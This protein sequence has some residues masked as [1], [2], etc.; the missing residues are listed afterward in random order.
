MEIDPRL[1]SWGER[2]K[3]LLNQDTIRTKL[4]PPRGNTRRQNVVTGGV[5]NWDDYSNKDGTLY[6]DYGGGYG[7]FCAY[8]KS[9]NVV[10]FFDPSGSTGPYAPDRRLSTAYRRV[11]QR[12]PHMIWRNH[13]DHGFPCQRNEE[14]TWC[15]TWSLAWLDWS[16]VAFVYEAEEESA[17][18]GI[19]CR[20]LVEAV[21]DRALTLRNLTRPQRA[22]FEWLRQTWDE[23]VR[24]AFLEFFHEGIP[25]F[26]V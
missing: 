2:Y 24:D 21:L 4:V 18:T 17:N 14:D 13:N 12:I 22:E 19:T 3:A 6:H 11:F 16:W 15:Q 10:T 8:R 25:S 20:N 9:G 26:E 1:E 5:Y 7:H 23:Y